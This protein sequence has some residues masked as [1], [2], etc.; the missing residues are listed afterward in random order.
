MKFVLNRNKTVASITG[1][2]VQFVKGE[3]IHVPPAMYAEV[4]AIGAVPEEEIDLEPKKDPNEKEEPTDP[5]ARRDEVYAA[6][7]RIALRGK[8]E[9]FTA[10]GAPHGT[11]LM[12]V[13]GWKLPNKERDQLWADFRQA[14]ED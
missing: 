5:Q 10:G 11:A 2:S 14:K 3:P 8:R 1:H 6:F 4:S 9:D 12:A 13:L 7:E